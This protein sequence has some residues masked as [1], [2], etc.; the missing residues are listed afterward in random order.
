MHNQENSY[1]L[2]SVH[3]LINK[4]VCFTYMSLKSEVLLQYCS[5]IIVSGVL[6]S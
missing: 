2:N 3:V 5:S 1:V 4:T 6:L